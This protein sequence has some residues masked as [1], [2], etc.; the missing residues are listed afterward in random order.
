MKLIF[1]H[2]TGNANVRAA[3]NALA[4]EDLL[5]QFYTSISSFP[6][7]FLDKISKYPALSEIKRREY[8]EILRPYAVMSP[9]FELGRMISLKAGMKR[10]TKHETGFF[11]IDR[12]FTELDKKV[13]RK[14]RKNKTCG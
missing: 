2:P 4:K 8:D 12:V 6:G 3:A 7:S 1:S 5:C 11:S 10:L 9:Y 13:A 14:L